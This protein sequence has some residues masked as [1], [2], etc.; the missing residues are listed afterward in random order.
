MDLPILPLLV[1]L[2]VRKKHR[3]IIGLNSEVLIEYYN[4]LEMS[5]Q[6]TF[7]SKKIEIPHFMLCRT[8]KDY[9]HYIIYLKIN[10][11]NLFEV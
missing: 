5:T 1:F 8:G 2:Y 6:K 11:D 3:W 9:A 7:S 4:S 10:I